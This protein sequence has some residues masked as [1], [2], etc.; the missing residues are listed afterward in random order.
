MTKADKSP[1]KRKRASR[2]PLQSSRLPFKMTE[3]RQVTDVKAEQAHAKTVFDEALKASKEI[4]EYANN[5][6]KLLQ[7]EDGIS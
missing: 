5:R 6:K 2:S 4:S 7:T 3:K 1:K